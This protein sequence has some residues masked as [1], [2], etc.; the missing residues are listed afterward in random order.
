VNTYQALDAKIRDML[1]ILQK[2]A[3]LF[4]EL[5]ND[6]FWP[7]YLERYPEQVS[8]LE[9]ASLANTQS[10]SAFDMQIQSLT[11]MHEAFSNILEHFKMT[12]GEVGKRPE[13]P[14]GLN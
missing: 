4:E 14:A 5:E 3:K 13:P 9:M 8:A 7:A 11:E 1:P 6:E 12:R 10:M 2:V